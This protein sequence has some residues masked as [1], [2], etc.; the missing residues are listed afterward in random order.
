M[1]IRK[2]RDVTNFEPPL[3]AAAY[4]AGSLRRSDENRWKLRSTGGHIDRF[5]LFFNDACFVA[6][7]DG[8][9]A[10]QPSPGP[11]APPAPA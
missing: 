9:S 5:C 8:W 7:A 2:Q 10:R 1:T 11:A 6:E 3:V 4:N